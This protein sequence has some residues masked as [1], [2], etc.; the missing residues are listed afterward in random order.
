MKPQLLGEDYQLDEHPGNQ[1]MRSL[2]LVIPFLCAGCAQPW[3]VIR[4]A[5]PNPFV[6]STSYDLVPL[7]FLARPVLK[8]EEGG[9]SAKVMTDMKQL[10]GAAFAE[11]LDSAA[12]PESKDRKV[13]VEA[14]VTK[15]GSANHAMTNIEN[16]FN[17]FVEIRV[18]LTSASQ[19][20]DE[21]ETKAEKEPGGAAFGLLGFLADATLGDSITKHGRLRGCASTLGENVAKYVRWRTAGGSTD[22]KKAKAKK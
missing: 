1:T 20:L 7:R 2:I 11:G 14:V 6:E 12:T 19:V 9:S 18:R 8:A 5:E 13:S 3:T 10:F 22:L 17:T 16:E 21:F 4:Q 15:I